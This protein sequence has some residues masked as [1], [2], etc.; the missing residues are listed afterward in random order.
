MTLDYIAYMLLHIVRK[1]NKQISLFLLV[2]YFIMQGPIIGS[3]QDSLILLMDDY[4]AMVRNHHPM[5]MQ[6]LLLSDVADAYELKAKAGFDPTLA[7]DYQAK[8]FDD[9]SYYRRLLSQVKV[10]TWIGADLKVEYERNRGDFLNES[11][12]LPENG[13]LLAGISIPLGQGLV[14]DERRRSLKEAQLY[15]QSNDIKRRELYNK[16]I[17]SASKSYVK[18]QV[19]HEKLTIQERIIQIAEE[20]LLITRTGYEVG[21]RPALDTLEALVNLRT[22]NQEFA[23]LQ[24]KTVVALN[25]VNNYLWDQGSMPLELE[26]N[27]RPELLDM[28]ISAYAVDTLLLQSEELIAQIPQLNQLRIEL[29]MVELDERLA[30]ENLKPELNLNFN[31]LLRVQ[32]NDALIRYNPRDYKW[33]LDFY[34]PLLN[35]KSRADLQLTQITMNQIRLDRDIIKQDIITTINNLVSAESN[36]KEQSVLI[37]DNIIDYQTLLSAEQE[38]YEIGESSLFLLNIRESKLLEATFKSIDIKEL[39]ILTRF[40]LINAYQSFSQ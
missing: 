10:P 22:R 4:L 17:Y 29:Q 20:R 34:Y 33:G 26:D 5:A 1:G 16:L 2:I 37:N 8:E 14:F 21:D 15:R 36:L 23:K 38:K 35:R 31:P 40:D 32:D 27:T 6:A 30:R 9:K 7:L 3:A 39:I 12:D 25:I 13:L 11:E 28:T 18:W 24:L 19:L